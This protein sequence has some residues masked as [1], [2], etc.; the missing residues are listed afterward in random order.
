MRASETSKPGVNMAL[1][2]ADFTTPESPDAAAIQSNSGSIATTPRQHS[3]ILIVDDE[4]VNVRITQKY[5]EKDGFTNFVTVTD[6]RQAMHC[7][8]KDNPALVLLDIV[9][10]HVSGLDI[11]Q[12]VRASPHHENL[13]VVILTAATDPETKLTALRMGATDFLAKPV[14]PSELI[15]RVRNMLV[16]K[17]YQDHLQAYAEQLEVAVQQRTTELAESRKHVIE[18]LARAAEYRDDDTGRH[19]IR[20][21]K[22]AGLIAHELGFSADDCVQIEQAAQLHDVGK[23]AIPDALLRKEDCLEEAEYELMR[24]HCLF[25]HKIIQPPEDHSQSIFQAHPEL[26][27]RILNVGSSELIRVAARI[28]LT[29]HEWWDGTGYPIGLAGEDIPIEGRITA[30]ADVFDALSS[31]RPYKR[32][33][34]RAKCFEIMAEESGSHFDPNVL[35]AFFRRHEEIVQIQLNNV[36]VS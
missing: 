31:A 27:A 10:P 6:S 22:Y 1:A 8:V 15:P 21:G 26:G 5:L 11:L 19:I 12:E 4:S 35:D 13:P 36:D 2:P 30:V 24:K 17:A 32:A 34:P 7:I 33:Y 23:I 14:D 16:V 29:H 25:G 3:K 9:M 20:V 28:A 18:C